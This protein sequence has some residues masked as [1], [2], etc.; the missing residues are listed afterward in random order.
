MAQSKRIY[1]FGSNEAGKH[2]SGEA[3]VAY[4]KHGARYGMSYGH[5]G[6]SFAIPLW[7]QKQEQLDPRRIWKYVQGFLAYA[8]GHPEL[9]FQITHLKRNLV[10]INIVLMF[11]TASPNCL[12]DDHWHPTLGDYHNYWGTY[13]D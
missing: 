9:I 10:G 8:Q 6:S 5:I 1:V 11:D 13:D 7:D 12:F 4:K 2:E 3:L